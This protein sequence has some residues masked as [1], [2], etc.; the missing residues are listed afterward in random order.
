MT[1]VFQVQD[2]ALLERVKAG[3]KIRFSAIQE[4]GAYIVTRIEAV[5]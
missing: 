5:K 2:P 4:R 3:D 1:M